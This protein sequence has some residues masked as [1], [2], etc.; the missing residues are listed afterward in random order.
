MVAARWKDGTHGTWSYKPEHAVEVWT[1]RANEIPAV[2][3]LSSSLDRRRPHTSTRPMTMAAAQAN[4]DGALPARAPTADYVIS[5]ESS[6]Q[7][8]KPLTVEDLKAIDFSDAPWHETGSTR[9]MAASSV[10]RA[11]HADRCGSPGGHEW[12]RLREPVIGRRQAMR[13]ER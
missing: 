8:G 6:D 5:A 9:A 4:R 3:E 10:L 7:S 12:D 2:R 11:V 1:A 13:I